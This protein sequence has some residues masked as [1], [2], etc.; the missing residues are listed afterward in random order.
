MSKRV[1][2]RM[3]YQVKWSR[4]LGFLA[5]FGQI[6]AVRHPVLHCMSHGNVSLQ[7]SNFI[8]PIALFYAPDSSDRDHKSIG[9]SG[10]EQTS[11]PDLAHVDQFRQVKL[12]FR[13][14]GAVGSGV[15]TDEHT[16]PPQKQ[17][18]CQQS[19]RASSMHG[20]MCWASCHV[21]AHQLIFCVL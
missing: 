3:L 16:A 10:T 13:S 4:G 18:Q 19:P 20:G 17:T 9:H 14:A 6:G 21:W 2:Q 7:A 12:K 5:R 15:L 8:H 1:K 11:A